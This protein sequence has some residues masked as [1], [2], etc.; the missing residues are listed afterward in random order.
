MTNDKCLIYLADLVH[1]HIGKG[2]FMF[3]LNIGYLSGYTK[4]E[5]GEQVE[6]RLFK[7]PLDLLKAVDDRKPGIVGLSN[8]TWNIDLN[9]RVLERVKQASP[10]TLTIM[11]GPDFPVEESNA[12][13]Y[14]KSRAGLDFYALFQ[15]EIGF[16]EI[17]RS[18]LPSRD[19]ESIKNGPIKNCAYFDK[20]NDSLVVGNIKSFGRDLEPIPSPYLNGL[21]DDFF[22]TNLIP[23]IET[24]RGCPYSCTYCAWGV[25]AQKQVALHSLEKVM[26][27]IEYIAARTRNTGL[28]NV[29]DANFGIVARDVEL[30]EFL[31]AQHDSTGYPRYIGM[32]CAKN[33]PDRIITIAETLGDMAS[34]TSSFQSLDETVQLNM[35]RDNISLQ[36][37]KAIQSHFSAKHLQTHSELILGLPGETKQSHLSAIRDLMETDTAIVCYNLRMLGGTEL[38]TPSQIDKFGIKTKH[39]LVDN[40]FGKYDGIVSLETE[41][42]VL[43]T[44]TMTEQ[45]ILYF[46]P[47]HWLIQFLWNYGY[48][49]EILHFLREEGVNPADFITRLI[50]MQASAPPKVAQLLNDFQADASSEWFES[51]EACIE[52]YSV[53]ENFDNLL[54][55]GFGK[56][57][58]VYTCRVLSEC[59]T[60]FDVYIA[61][62][63]LN[64]LSD[65]NRDSDY[66]NTLKDIMLFTGNRFVD[67]AEELEPD[68][69]KK[70][71]VSSDVLAWKT[72][73]YSRPLREYQSGEGIEYNFFL[74]QDQFE[75]LNQTLRQFKQEDLNLTLRKMME[76]MKRSDLFYNVERAEGCRQ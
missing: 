7:F 42:M 38:N 27:E 59:K 19:I 47:I 53:P 15:G 64:C 21:L 49:T 31:R 30:A 5:F 55:G 71:R 40:A 76:Y 14:M 58:F 61:S 35:K 48:Y 74:S 60:E 62:V 33:V 12:L 63:A 13:E 16:S 18:F 17:V 50:E 34:V 26:A 23:I 43:S 57:N 72:D 9:K 68:F 28:L 3:P 45:D 22:D 6:I 4:L 2:P 75:A 70:V 24:N 56:L 66:E 10:Q 8:Y 1:N 11:G 36:D 37:F 32:A 54:K 46:R 41:E 67:F 73:A 39:R 29:A 69:E 44:D 52:H 20:E 25:S 65:L 51:H